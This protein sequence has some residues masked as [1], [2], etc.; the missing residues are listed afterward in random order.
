MTTSSAGLRS[1]GCGSTGIPRP[2]SV[3]SAPPSRRSVTV[4]ERAA[5]ARCSST[6]LSTTS[7]TRWCSPRESVDPTYMPG[8]LRTASRPSR[9]AM[10]LAS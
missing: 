2:S 4:M 8:R 3:T 7:H 9:T 1:L 5:P 10:D 6:A